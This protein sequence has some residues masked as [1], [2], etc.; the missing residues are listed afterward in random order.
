MIGRKAKGRKE[1][2]ARVEREKEKRQK[3]EKWFVMSFCHDSFS[4]DSRT[5]SPSRSR[6][7]S[8]SPTGSPERG[9]PKTWVLK[10]RKNGEDV[11]TLELGI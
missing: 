4:S 7:N 8:K 6:S 1:K 2:K 5:P 9:G 3:E 10:V 11:E